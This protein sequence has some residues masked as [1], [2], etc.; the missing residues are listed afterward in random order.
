DWAVRLYVKSASISMGRTWEQALPAQDPFRTVRRL[1]VS[2]TAGRDRLTVHQADF[3]WG[4]AAIHAAGAIH[5]AEKPITEKSKKAAERSAKTVSLI[6]GVLNRLKLEQPLDFSVTFLIDP[7]A[8]ETNGLD[9]TLST[10]RFIW[11]NRLY[12]R[13][14]GSGSIRG[15]AV[16]LSGLELVRP[17]GTLKL[18]GTF[19]SATTETGLRIV[20][21]FPPEDLI[22]LL[23][24]SA[25]TTIEHSGI[26]CS[27][28]LDFSA[29]LGPAP[30]KQLPEQIELD[31]RKTRIERQDLTL[32]SLAFHLTRNADRLTVSNLT[33]T[34][35][36]GPLSGS[37]EMNLDSKAWAVSAKAQC[38][39]SP[40]GTLTGGG[41]QEFL[42]RFRFPKTM[43]KGNLGIRQSGP[44]ES[45]HIDGTLEAENFL[46]GG[47]PVE[48]MTTSI[49]YADH[50]LKLSDLKAA[51]NQKRFAGQIEVNFTDGLA[52]FKA[53]GSF[54][55]SD[56]AH[57]LAPEHS[58]ILDQF[59]FPGT[60]AYTGEGRVDYRHSTN[61]LFRGSFHA[62]RVFF[63]PVQT[64]VFDS[65]I[66][67]RGS[68]LIFTNTSMQFCNGV[69][70]GAAQFDLKP[71]DGDA[72]YRVS[73]RLTKLDFTKLL[74]QVST[75][76]LSH[77]SGLL[78][79]NVSLSADA[80]AGFWNSVSGYGRVEIEKG[81]L[82]DLPLF[83]G[84]SRLVQSTIPS[85]NLFS[86]TSFSADY[87]LYN[88]SVRSDNARF[89]GTLLSARARG[90]WTPDQGLNFTVQA[91]PLRQTRDDKSWYDVHLWA[92]D[93]I[94]EGTA[95]FFWFLEFKVTGPLNQ[96]EW[97]FSNL[98]KEISELLNRS[99]SRSDQ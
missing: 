82:A 45:L 16:T 39:P 33:A 51:R 85:F 67:V 91:E 57:V 59:D 40:I 84:F 34:A 62:D 60:V 89:G 32:D 73:A 26:T 22:A 35:N 42:G 98:P 15:T 86:L 12:D 5:L 29:T 64:G 53:S 47:V 7:T 4:E 77:A 78:S 8:P 75:Q 83:G 72:P 27:G 61:H 46:C 56:I 99:K 6:T 76:Q 97:R 50:I 49:Q 69:V 13:M 18:S 19:D 96:P 36:G 20:S 80:K 48:H 88:G 54:P 28:D 43:P 44:G 25:G 23:P 24:E 63:D 3:Q 30:L 1:K 52:N 68:E 81:K 65:R 92:A 21:T 41:L 66:A 37:F 94:K 17:N 58:T 14:K 10:G 90:R 55:P 31:V 93:L 74:Q 2:L 95:P 38:D 79:G 70:E 87:E 71:F 11:Q 9:A